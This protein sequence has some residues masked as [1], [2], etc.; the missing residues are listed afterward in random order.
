MR[1]S[2]KLKEELFSTTKHRYNMSHAID[3]K[4]G[5]PLTDKSG[6]VTHY[7]VP[8]WPMRKT[9]SLRVVEK[10]V[11]AGIVHRVKAGSFPSI[12]KNAT[13]INKWSGNNPAKEKLYSWVSSG[14]IF[15]CTPHNEKVC[16]VPVKGGIEFVG[17]AQREALGLTPPKATTTKKAVKAKTAKKKLKVILKKRKLAR[18]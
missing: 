15:F 11:N 4:M 9:K 7:G 10:A 6:K 5:S 3:S 8:L 12:P 13:Q 17:S 2:V 14:N 1:C 16:Y 18:A